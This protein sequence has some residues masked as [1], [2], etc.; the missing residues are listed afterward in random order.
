MA[1]CPCATTNPHLRNWIASQGIPKLC[2]LCGATDQSTVDS[3]LLAEHIDGVIRQ[4]YTPDP[5]DPEHG[6]D[7]TCLIR[8]VAGVSTGMASE[9]Q[10]VAHVDE[11]HN[12]PTFYD[13]APLHF[14]GH[15]FGKHSERWRSLKQI[16]KPDPTLLSNDVRSILDVLLR[17][18]HS[19]CGGA[20]I[21]SLTPGE[22]IFRARQ[23][24]CLKTAL[25]WYR[26]DDDSQL[27]APTTRR[28]N[29]MNAEGIRV[30]YGALQDR[31]A[32]AEV[33][34][35]IGTHVVVGVF[36]PTR[37]LTILDLGAL[38]DIFE[39]HD[40]FEPGF[41]EAAE[42]LTFFRMLDREVSL[43]V[44][45]ADDSLANRPTQ[46]LAEYVRS[47]LGLD[48]L[49]Y[50]S[51]QTGE[52]PAWGQLYGPRLDRFERNVV[53]LGAAAWTTSEQPDDA[54]DSGLQFLPELRQVVDVSKIEIHHRQ[55]LQA[56]Y[57][58]PRSEL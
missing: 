1:I 5:D 40:L 39:Y 24:H 30:F 4:H 20:A 55:N 43:P 15:V 22:Y 3:S 51:T 33:Q 47:V 14:S 56:H 25:G 21:R 12:G 11:P 48:G 6:E 46:V 35:P 32:I 57:E 8:R 27:R 10:R 50:R 31:I 54:G 37:P 26:A 52:V 7:P 41:A 9:V 29:R 19:F 53:L 44:K 58:S 42:R 28:A 17:D 45:S 13:Y 34:P 23:T 38:G 16:L 2:D 18:I 36:T 49:A